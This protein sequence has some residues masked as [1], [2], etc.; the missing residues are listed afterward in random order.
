[1]AARRRVMLS[2]LLS[3]AAFR[4]PRAPPRARRAA[5]RAL[6]LDGLLLAAGDSAT[7]VE[8]VGS[9]IYGPIFAGGIALFAA[10]VGGAL[11]TAIIIDQSDAYERLA[12]DFSA[13]STRDLEKEFG[14]EAARNVIEGVKT[15]T[16]D[17]DLLGGGGGGDAAP[18]E[19][20]A[21]AA[22]DDGYDD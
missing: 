20:G 14:A 2:L 8:A 13:A 9:E 10:G 15:G 1:M 5:P 16:A 19:T 11:V 18:V 22:A 17:R 21:A 6:A 12:E 3:A 4:A 7:V